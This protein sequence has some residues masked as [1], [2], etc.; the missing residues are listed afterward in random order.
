MKSQARRDSPSEDERKQHSFLGYCPKQTT[1]SGQVDGGVLVYLCY[2][3]RVKGAPEACYHAE[4]LVGYREAINYMEETGREREH[5]S[6]RVPDAS[7]F[8]CQ[9]IF[10]G[11]G[12]EASLTCLP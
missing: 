1:D 9:R 4:W 12:H 8:I 5:G 6:R 10:P 7:C 11:K 3:V 2:G